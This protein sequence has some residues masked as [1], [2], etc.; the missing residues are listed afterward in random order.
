[1][2]T[3]SK[4]VS[5]IEAPTLDEPVPLA[6]EETAAVGGGAPMGVPAGVVRLGR[7]LA[8]ALLN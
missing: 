2:T 1:M 5:H 8:E 7:W 4:L 6:D 3:D